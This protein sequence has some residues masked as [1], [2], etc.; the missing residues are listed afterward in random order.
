M[1]TLG[2]RESCSNLIFAEVEL[3]LLI[4][5]A[6]NIVLF[7]RGGDRISLTTNIHLYIHLPSHGKK[8]SAVG[9]VVDISNH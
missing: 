3:F 5:G 8:S 9:F 2:S 6:L 4:S 7:V 1:E